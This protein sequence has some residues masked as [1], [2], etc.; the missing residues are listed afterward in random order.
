MDITMNE[1]TIPVGDASVSAI[2]D[3]PTTPPARKVV[4]VAAHGAGGNKQDRAMQGTAKTLIAR[5]LH[6][7]RH[8]FLYSERKS[9]RPDPIEKAAACS[10]MVAEY[11]RRALHPDVLIIGGRSFG[12]RAAS[13]IA[14]D[15][16]EAD[17]LLLLAY[18]LHPAGN[19]EKLR[20][21]HL[22]SIRMPVLCFNGTRDG[23]CT[24]EIM[25]DILPRVGANWTMHWVDGA[26]HSF[27]VLK[28]SGRNDGAVQDE[29]GDATRDWIAAI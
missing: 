29:I 18:P 20:D 21:S 2:H 16:F 7:V 5:G 1:L 22:P 17:G 9:G 28:S 19:P 4:F 13:L 15:G 24:P 3:E 27:H 8:N 11:V 14:A 12:G 10:Q 6:V 23:L 25:N 26:D